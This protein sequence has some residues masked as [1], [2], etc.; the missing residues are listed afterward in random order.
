[1]YVIIGH[2]FA[3]EAFLLTAVFVEQMLAHREG[4][5]RP[6]LLAAGAF[7]VPLSR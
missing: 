7:G 6:L 2:I 5:Y 1:M 4:V 3:D